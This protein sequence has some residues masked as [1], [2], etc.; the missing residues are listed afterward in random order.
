[1]TCLLRVVGDQLYVD[2]GRVFARPYSNVTPEDIQYGKLY[3]ISGNRVTLSD[4]MDGTGE[5]V[6]IDLAESLDTEP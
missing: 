1:M 6:R 4:N 3:S 2:T 5:P